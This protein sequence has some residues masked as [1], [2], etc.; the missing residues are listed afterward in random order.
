MCFFK[1]KLLHL[2]VYSSDDLSRIFEPLNIF[3]LVNWLILCSSHYLQASAKSERKLSGKWGNNNWKCRKVAGRGVN[4]GR[5][6]IPSHSLL[7]LSYSS[8]PNLT[9]G[10]PF[11]DLVCKGKCLLLNLTTSREPYTRS[12]PTRNPAYWSLLVSNLCE[13]KMAT[14]SKKLDR[15]SF[16]P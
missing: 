11:L 15:R 4:K 13:N 3:L 5:K 9:N 1:Y 6:R 7:P 8:S 14:T 10:S 2:I 16:S 12:Q